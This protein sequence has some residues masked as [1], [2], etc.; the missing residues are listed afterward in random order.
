MVD[1]QLLSKYAFPPNLGAA[2]LPDADSDTCLVLMRANN[3]QPVASVVVV[4]DDDWYCSAI[5]PGCHH[6]SETC[7]GGS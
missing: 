1:Q 2:G 6:S 3:I 7:R 5:E 4:D